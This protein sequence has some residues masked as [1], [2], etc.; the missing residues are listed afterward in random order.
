MLHQEPDGRAVRAAAEA[1]VE[2]LG[3]RDRER[4]RLLA[5]ERAQP[6]P[7][8]PALLQ[9]HVAADHVKLSVA[10]ETLSDEEL[11]RIAAQPNAALPAPATAPLDDDDDNP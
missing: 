6:E 2:L 5:V 8:R 3:R 4:R 10:V 11:L 9:L 1:V 7:V